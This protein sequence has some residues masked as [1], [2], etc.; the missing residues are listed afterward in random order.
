MARSKNIWGQLVDLCRIMH[1]S[2][3][4]NRDEVEAKRQLPKV[5][6]LLEQTPNADEAIITA[7]AFALCHEL[8]GELE[9]AI[10]YRRREAE[11]M[12]RLYE[13][14]RINNYDDDVKQALL[15]GRDKEDL[16]ARKA[17]LIELERRSS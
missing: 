7:E 3:Y 1:K 15:E 6:A 8:R 10:W 5:E 2:M 12:E 14:I 9:R 16:E 4:E 17:I 11:L 13:D